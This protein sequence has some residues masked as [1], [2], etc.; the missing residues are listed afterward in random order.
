M[1]EWDGSEF[2]ALAWNEC[3]TGSLFKVCDVLANV[4]IKDQ[5][6]VGILLFNSVDFD[7][8]VKGSICINGELTP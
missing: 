5:G 8:I 4:L 1:M 7:L 2:R 6:E 3:S